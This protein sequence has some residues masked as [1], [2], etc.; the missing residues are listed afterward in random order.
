MNTHIKTTAVTLSPAI[1]EYINKHVAKIENLFNG[2]D[3]VK[4]DIEIGRTTAHHHKGDIFRAEIHIVGHK[5]NIFAEAERED[6]T[7]AID[8]VFVDAQYSMTSRRKKIIG[9]ARNG[10][11]KIKSMMRG[12]WPFGNS[13]VTATDESD[14]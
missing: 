8:E 10:G 13:D 1:S 14:E 3:S 5:Q 4:C 6:L 12:M 11:A 7:M 2:D 9:L